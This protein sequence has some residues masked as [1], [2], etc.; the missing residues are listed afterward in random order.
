MPAPVLLSQFYGNFYTGLTAPPAPLPNT[1]WGVNIPVVLENTLANAN[2][3]SYTPPAGAPP[4]TCAWTARISITDSSSSVR[5]S[6]VA[7]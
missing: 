5:V 1:S 7:V 4:Q 3:T 6:V 2:N